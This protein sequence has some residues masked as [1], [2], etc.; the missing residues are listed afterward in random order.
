[1][2]ATADE[3]EHCGQEVIKRIAAEDE[4]SPTLAAVVQHDFRH[5]SALPT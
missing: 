2:A 3:E 4:S 1:M 5:A